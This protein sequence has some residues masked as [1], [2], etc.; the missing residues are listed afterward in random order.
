[1]SEQGR[2]TKDQFLVLQVTALKQTVRA[3]NCLQAAKLYYIGDVIQLTEDELQQV[4]N[5]T[6][7]AIKELK[8]KLDSM[9]L[10]LGTKLENW[11]PA[12]LPYP[13]EDD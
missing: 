6:T 9:N 12:D 7:V 1:M 8:E 5:L 4:P 11:P 13:P 10:P 3:T 2:L